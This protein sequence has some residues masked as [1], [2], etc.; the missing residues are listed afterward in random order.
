MVSVRARLPA[1]PK[2]S[3]YLTPSVLI[4]RAALRCDRAFRAAARES[5]SSAPDAPPRAQSPQTAPA[6]TAAPP[7]A[8]AEFRAAPRAPPLS[9]TAEYLCQ[10]SAG[11]WASPA[12]APALARFRAAPA[13]AAAAPNHFR[14]PSLP[15]QA[16]P[17]RLPPRRSRTTPAPAFPP[18]QFRTA[19]TASRRAP[20]APPI[21]PAPAQ[22][23]PPGRQYSSQ[24]KDKCQPS[25]CKHSS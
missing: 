22:Y 2:S 23:A 12:R 8:D 4:R 10:R 21:A 5:F 7:S 11:L 16:V 13:S 3:L 6:R 14:R 25:P 1:L 17:F 19:P 9:R 18:A 24:E 20:C 15:D